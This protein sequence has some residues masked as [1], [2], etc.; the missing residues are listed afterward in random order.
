[1][2]TPKRCSNNAPNRQHA[3]TLATSP[4]PSWPRIAHSSTQSWFKTLCWLRRC[5]SRAEMSGSPALLRHLPP[6]TKIIHS[7]FVPLRPFGLR[8]VFEPQKLHRT[9]LAAVVEI[10]S[11]MDLARTVDGRAIMNRILSRGVSP[12][13]ALILH[14]QAEQEKIS[15]SAREGFSTGE[16]LAGQ[17]MRI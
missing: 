1:M 4:P 14:A 17:R 16:H 11:H 13:V 15:R 3:P 5:L 9:P 10:V 6:Q 7:S 8:S 2:P 12:D